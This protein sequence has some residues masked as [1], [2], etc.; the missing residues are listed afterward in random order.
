MSLR[1]FAGSLIRTWLQNNSPWIIALRYGDFWRYRQLLTGCHRSIAPKIYTAY[2][3]RFNSFI[4]INARI[5][6]TPVFPHGLCGVF[7]SNSANIGNGVIIYHHVTIG[8]NTVEGSKGY[9]APTIED[10][11]LIGAGAKIIGNITIGRNSRIG[12]GCVVTKDIPANAVVVMPQPRIIQKDNRT[13]HFTSNNG[14]L[15]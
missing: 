9:G 13:N 10:G 4:G 5:A 2:L 11:V 12:A 8:S 14:S 1:T 3:D 15:F 6:G 7:I